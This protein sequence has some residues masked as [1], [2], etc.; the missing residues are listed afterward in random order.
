MS[1]ILNILKVF[2]MDYEFDDY[3]GIE[4]AVYK[5]LRELERLFAIFDE[6]DVASIYEAMEGVAEGTRIDPLREL[7]DRFF[8]GMMAKD[9]YYLK[10]R[11]LLEKQ[12]GLWWKIRHWLWG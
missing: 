3:E 5:A 7:T 10:M 12:R 11:I 9:E 1:V 8:F 6:P 4:V 2:Q